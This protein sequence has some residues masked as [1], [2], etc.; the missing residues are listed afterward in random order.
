MYGLVLLAIALSSMLPLLAPLTF[1]VSMV[2]VH[3]FLVR[4][5]IRWLGPG[6]RL[7]VRVT[8]KLLLAALT[9]L[10]LLLNTLLAPALG[11]AQVVTVAWATVATVVFLEGSLWLVRNRLRREATHP[12]LDLWEILLPGSLIGGLLGLTL[13]SLF[14]TYALLHLLLWMD[15][16]GLT[17]IVEFLLASQGDT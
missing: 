4:R 5:P 1:A 11:I 8:L 13:L 16:P 2:C 17:D 14:A 10:G 3:L 6:R 15:L 12:R 7:A 9:W